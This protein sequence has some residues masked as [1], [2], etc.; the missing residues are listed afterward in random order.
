MALVERLYAG[1]IKT[2]ANI[3]E[4]SVMQRPNLID[5]GDFRTRRMILQALSCHEAK[6]AAV[7]SDLGLDPRASYS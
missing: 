5:F 1:Q 2:C 3:C 6:T 4:I 7:K